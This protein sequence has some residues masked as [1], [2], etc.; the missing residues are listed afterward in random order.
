VSFAIMLY[1][2]EREYIGPF[3]ITKTVNAYIQEHFKNEEDEKRFVIFT[4]NK[5]KWRPYIGTEEK[6]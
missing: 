3:I 1:A 4:C 5:N 6:A 2:M